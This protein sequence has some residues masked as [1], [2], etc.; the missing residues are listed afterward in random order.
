MLMVLQARQILK[1][2]KITWN[3]RFPKIKNSM[4]LED[5]LSKTFSDFKTH[6]SFYCLV[7]NRHRFWTQSP[8]LYHF[9]ALLYDGLLNISTFWFLYL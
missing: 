2:N 8:T 3:W 5:T 1:P 4:A 9:E 6:D 7:L